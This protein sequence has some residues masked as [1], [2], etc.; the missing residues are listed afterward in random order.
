MGPPASPPAGDNKSLPAQS[1]AGRDKSPPHQPLPACRALGTSGQLS[2]SYSGE[3]R[4]EKD[5][6]SGTRW[7]YEGAGEKDTRKKETSQRTDSITKEEVEGSPRMRSLSLRSL[8]IH[9]RT[10]RDSRR[11][12]GSRRPTS[13]TILENLQTILLHFRVTELSLCFSHLQL[14]CVTY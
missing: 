3:R 6:E 5:A 9:V 13:Q 7:D 12:T 14:Y 2:P 10:R 11:T 1:A 8:T 4:Q